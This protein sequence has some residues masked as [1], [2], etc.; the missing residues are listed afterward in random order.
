MLG[1]VDTA[2]LGHLA[3]PVYLGAVAV[4]A[5]LLSIL[6][7]AFGFLRMGTT[8]LTGRLFGAEDF[9]ELGILLARS[10]L[11]AL[12][13]ALGLISLQG[14]AIPLGLGWIANGGEVEK[15]ASEYARIRIWSAPATLVNYCFIGWLIGLQNTRIPMIIMIATNVLNIALDYLLIIV[16]DMNSAGAAWASIASEYT[17]LILAITLVRLEIR[18]LHWT[19]EIPAILAAVAKLKGYRP[20]LE[21]NRDLF[22]RTLALMFAIAF[23]TAQGARM[24]ENILAANAILISLLHVA[25]F[26]LDGIAHATEAM[27]G[28]A[29]GANDMAAFRRIVRQSTQVAVSLAALSSVALFLLDTPI[30]AGFT[31]LAEV[32]T[33]TAMYYPWLALL[34]VVGVLAYQF[35]GIFIGIGMTRE[36]LYTMLI[37][38]FIVFLPTW[39]LTRELGNHGLWLAL[40]CWLASRGITQYLFLR[41]RLLESAPA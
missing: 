36:M 30:I 9:D 35:D 24:G 7:W 23:V 31:S 6:F 1:V 22:F 40:W 13:L 4:G 39:W 21:V 3:S 15:L 2:I 17:G 5:Q 25:A 41:P 28:K 32:R 18:K 12:A 11:M 10:I 37:A 34:P 26:G 19:P 33:T 14:F 29:W 20:L 27:T 8:S 38:T 16:L